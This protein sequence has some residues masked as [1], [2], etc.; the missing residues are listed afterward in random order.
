MRSLIVGVIASASLGYLV[1]TASAMGVAT[2]DILDAASQQGLIE[3]AQYDRYC[4]RLRR[5]CEFKSE[6]G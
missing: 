1:S 6:R 2:G 5:A 3:Q 4:A